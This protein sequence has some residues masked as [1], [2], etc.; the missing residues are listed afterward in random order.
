MK[1]NKLLL[2]LLSPLLLTQCWW[3]SF[4]GTS[5]HPQAQTISVS[6][7]E[8][9]AERINPALSNTFTESL[10]DKYTKLTRLS[11]IREDGDYAVDGYITGYN[12]APIAVTSDEVASMARLTVTIKVIFQN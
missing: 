8:N 10:M 4:S 6:Y 12:M 7:I 2:L 5:I 3:Y 1:L 9:R 11:V